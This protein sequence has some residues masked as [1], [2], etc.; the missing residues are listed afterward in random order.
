MSVNWNWNEK[1]GKI[2]WKEKG[3]N[4]E[5]EW[6]FYH[7]NCWGCFIK[8]DEKTYEFMTFFND[9][10]HT[11]KMLGLEKMSNGI[12]EDYF[13]YIYGNFE[14]DHIE[15]DLSYPYNDKIAKYFA[16]AG[17]TVFIQNK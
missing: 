2:V 9:S 15:L 6:N 11:K 8:E 10:H 7:A 12:K 5:I 14:I 17:Y 13:K 4:G 3:G 16:Q 1:K